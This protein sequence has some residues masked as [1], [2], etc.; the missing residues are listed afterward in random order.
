VSAPTVQ[1]F[2]NPRP[3]RRFRKRLEALEAAFAQAGATLIVSESAS[4]RLEVDP[5]ADQVCSVGGDGTL[6]NVV[7]AVLRCGRPIPIS[8]Y[9]AGT[10]NLV[11]R[12]C[13]YPRA[14]AAFVRRLLDQGGHRRHHFARIGR[15]PMLSCA[16]VG[17]DS[18]VVA[19]LSP[20]LK[21]RIG[22]LAYL[23]AFARLLR[24][25]PRTRMIVWCD[26]QPHA[27]EAVYIAKGRHFAGPWSFAPQA[28]AQEPML[29]VVML[30]QATRR[31]ALRFF[32]QLLLG[33]PAAALKG[34]RCLQCTRLEITSATSAPVQADGDIV[35]HLPAE[36]AIS[37][38]TMTFA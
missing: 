20:G 4:D 16:S 38:G 15:T 2:V 33:R 12:E 7:E 24:R 18:H 35:Q 32:L 11:A 26:G 28:S 5:R 34:V 3:G 30:D 13:G 8:T 9:P 36:I 22:R 37:D 10:V 27:C 19:A 17:P 21:A 31:R 14:P 1:L 23:W 25:W 29:Q 6:R